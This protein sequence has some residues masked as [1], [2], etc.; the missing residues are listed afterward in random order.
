MIIYTGSGNSFGSTSFISLTV[1]PSMENIYDVSL[2]SAVTILPPSTTVR[3]RIVKYIWFFTKRYL[4]FKPYIPR[5]SSLSLAKCTTKV[6]SSKNR[7][8][9]S[10]P[11]PTRFESRCQTPT[12]SFFA[13]Q[14]ESFFFCPNNCVTSMNELNNKM[15][16]F[17][18]I[19]FYNP[20]TLKAALRTLPTAGASILGVTV[21]LNL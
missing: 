2:D 21:G 14:Q 11:L 8:F 3:E 6:P 5:A 15:I 1:P 16:G 17:I 12:K 13:I 20:I 9:C 10:N 19:N 18:L 7:K 4:P